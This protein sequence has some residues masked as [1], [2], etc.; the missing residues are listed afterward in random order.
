MT[1]EER[2][3]QTFP[4]RATFL[5]FEYLF[6]YFDLF[7]GSEFGDRETEPE[8]EPEISLGQSGVRSRVG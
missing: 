6:I 4:D 2:N 5:L 1:G 3:A 7:S 8:P